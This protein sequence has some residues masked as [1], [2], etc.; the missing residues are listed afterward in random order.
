MRHAVKHTTLVVRDVVDVVEV[1]SV[2]DLA[3]GRDKSGGGREGQ[4]ESGGDAHVYGF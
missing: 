4:G 1:R 3:L 2:V